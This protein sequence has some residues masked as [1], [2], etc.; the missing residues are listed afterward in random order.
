M[1]NSEQRGFEYEAWEAE[2]PGVLKQDPLWKMT[3]YRL[4]LF[5]A[6]LGWRDV[7][8]LLGDRRTLSI[9]DQL[10]RALGSISANVAEGYSRGTGRDRARFYEYAL[11]SSRESRDWYYKGRYILGETV[12]EHRLKLLTE[13]I[14]L[15]LVTAPRERNHQVR[16]EQ[17]E[18]QAARQDET[19]PGDKNGDFLALMHDIPLPGV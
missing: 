14:R 7:T 9:A 15:L 12:A 18:Y 10:Y 4:A 17:G 5:A 11:G 2:V 16:E 1:G 13:V 3:V 8:R 6:D 19:A